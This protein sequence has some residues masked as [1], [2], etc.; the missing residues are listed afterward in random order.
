MLPMAL[1]QLIDRQ[2]RWPKNQHAKA[3]GDPVLQN[4]ALPIAW[5]TR[6]TS[7]PALANWPAEKLKASTPPFAA[8]PQILCHRAAVIFYFYP[9]TV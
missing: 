2:A 8:H 4:N 5:R 9:A 3:T 6:A 1:A 7:A